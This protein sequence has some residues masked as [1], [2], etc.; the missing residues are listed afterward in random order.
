MK[1][2][3]LICV[4]PSFLLADLPFD[5]IAYYLGK[6]SVKEELISVLKEKIDSIH[7]QNVNSESLESSPSYLIGKLE[8]YTLIKKEIEELEY[9]KY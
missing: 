4:L 8:G 6:T 3:L 2:L 1:K 5:E 9:F 7:Y